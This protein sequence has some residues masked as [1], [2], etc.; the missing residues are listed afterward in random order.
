MIDRTD[1]VSDT[2]LAILPP[3]FAV[4]WVI[5][6]AATGM[7]PADWAVRVNLPVLQI[8]SEAKAANAPTLDTTQNRAPVVVCARFGAVAADSNAR[9][10]PGAPQSSLERLCRAGLKFTLALPKI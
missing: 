3:I 9:K 7:A 4:T 10:V 1:K 2:I 5:A 8:V 6:D